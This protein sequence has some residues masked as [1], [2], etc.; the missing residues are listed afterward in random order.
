M[1]FEHEKENN[2]EVV[3]RTITGHKIINNDDFIN[4]VPP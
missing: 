1:T 4:S 3:Y 2:S